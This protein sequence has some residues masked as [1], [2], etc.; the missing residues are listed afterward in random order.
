MKNKFQVKDPKIILTK[1]EGVYIPGRGFYIPGR[2]TV[3]I[4][5]WKKVPLYSGIRFEKKSYED[6]EFS[7]FHDVDI[8]YTNM[9]RPNQIPA[10]VTNSVLYDLHLA[11]HPGD[12]VTIADVLTILGCCNIEF[13]IEDNRPLDKI[14]NCPLSFIPFSSDPFCRD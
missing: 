14:I 5:D 8:P 2:G 3:Q 9:K 4:Y 6:N 11:C 1:P 13:I 12:G 7:L 10:N